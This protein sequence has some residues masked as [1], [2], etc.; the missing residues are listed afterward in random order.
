MQMRFIACAV[1]LRAPGLFALGWQASFNE[2]GDSPAPRTGGRG[3]DASNRLR[4]LRLT[5]SNGLLFC[6]TNLRSEAHLP[7]QPL[8]HAD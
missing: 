4:L 1:A 2:L 5:Y 6:R 3:R 7:V 8:S